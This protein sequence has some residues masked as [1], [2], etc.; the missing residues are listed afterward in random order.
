M[1]RK[2]VSDRLKVKIKSKKNLTESSRRW[3]ERQ[4]N[5]PYVLKAKSEG[6]RSRAAYKLIEIDDKFKILKPGHIVIDLGACP[7]GWT[8]VAVARVK[9]QTNPKAKV[10]GID[11][12]AMSEIPG[13]TLLHAD[14]T[15]DEAQ[16]KLIALLGGDEAKVHTVLSDMAAPA[17]GMPSVDHTR[18][19]MLLEE[20]FL[21]ATK[22]LLP[23]G[24]FVAKVL[25]GGTETKLLQT[26]KTS[27]QKVTHFKP[28][29][30]R[31][32]SAEMYVVALGFRGN[33]IHESPQ[34][35]LN[36]RNDILPS[37]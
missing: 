33:K 22:V 16:E 11:L 32:G 31:Q 10:I 7:G 27:F 35:D 34:S 8:Q 21:F 9:S 25:R 17:C 3:L 2:T 24:S 5:D 23:G 26:L 30:S 29:A 14:F 20:A 15:T 13:A 28:P 18:I 6:Y 1:T 37:T 12:T 36:K 4:L 19:M